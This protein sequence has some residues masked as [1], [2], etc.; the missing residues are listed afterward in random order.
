MLTKIGSAIPVILIVSL[1]LIIY[2]NSLGGKFLWDDEYLIQRNT[3]IRSFSNIPKIF[4]QDT[5]A[6]SGRFFGFYRPLYILSYNVDYLLYGLKV[7]GYHLTNIILH[8]LASLCLLKLFNILFDQPLVSLA[9]ALLFLA[10][11]MNTATVSYMSGRADS[12]VDLFMLLSFIFYAKDTARP[13]RLS[14]AMIFVTYAMAILTK[15]SS[16]FFPALILLYHYSFNKKIELKRFVPLIVIALGYAVLRLTALKFLI[17]FGPQSIAGSTTILQRLPGFFAS[18]VSYAGI[19]IVP[20]DLHMGRGMVRFNFSDPI[21]V[22]GMLIFAGIAAA[23]FYLRKAE[24]PSMYF[25]GIMWFII[26]IL[27]VSNVY[28]INAYMAEHWLALPAMGLFLIAGEAFYSMYKVGKL[29]YYAIAL[30]AAAVLFYGYATIRQNSYWKDAISFHFRTLAYEPGNVKSMADLA[31]Q[32]EAVGRRE[33]AARLYSR[34]IALNKDFPIPYNNLGLLYHNAGRDDLS[35]GLYKKALELDPGY[36]D[37]LNNLA[38]VYHSTGKSEEAIGLYRRAIAV[39]PNF[40]GAYSN[41]GVLCAATGKYDEALAAYKKAIE[42]S[43][44]FPDPYYNLGLLYV[45]LGRTDEAFAAYN[46][47]LELKPDLIQANNNIGVLYFKTGQYDRAIQYLDKAASLGFKVDPGIM[48][49]LAR[50]RK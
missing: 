3:Y 45:A 49:E 38:V 29:K 44:D 50:Y 30:L 28:A 15:E 10:H 20:L 42:I 14:Y 4:T 32:Y 19:L 34:A 6:G 16:L 47:A 13:G 26:F 12:M 21:V 2:G 36:P 18:L 41:M 25:F 33:E 35:V 11:P 37:A 24:R 40:S 22:A 1:G 9:A 8:I 23:A 46:K 48:S 27:P 5:G 43:P 39:N 31:R 7:W 17:A